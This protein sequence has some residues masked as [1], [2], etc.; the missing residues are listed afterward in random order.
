MNYV[1][2]ADGSANGRERAIVED[3]PTERWKKLKRLR[4]SLIFLFFFVGL[5]IPK[6]NVMTAPDLSSREIAEIWMGR[7][8]Y[9]LMLIAIV[10]VGMKER[11]ARLFAQGKFQP[12][13]P[14]S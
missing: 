14:P 8:L 11:R 5:M 4:W 1:S 9:F 6:Y 7:I 2:L 13:D 12:P 3:D 10:A